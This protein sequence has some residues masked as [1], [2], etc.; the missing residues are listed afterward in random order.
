MKDFFKK[1]V[2][3]IQFLY[4]K[5]SVHLVTMSA[6]GT[7]WLR[8]MI[9]LNLSDRDLQTV[10]VVGVVPH[11]FS[12]NSIPI[13][14]SH[15]NYFPYA[16]KAKTLMLVRDIRDSLV[17]HY[18]T[19]VKNKREDVSFGVFLRDKKISKIYG[20][21]RRVKFLNSWYLNKERCDDFMLVRYEDLKEDTE[22]VMKKVFSFL[23]IDCVD[24]EDT[25]TR[26]SLVEMKKLK[27]PVGK[28][29]KGVVGRYKEYFTKEDEES[30]ANIAKII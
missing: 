11:L 29:K 1:F 4:K 26:S 18:E 23:T 17:S 28:I 19:F 6:S 24:I 22:G 25:I 12:Y 2:S 15:S 21:E 16:R 3:T 14:Q 7:H 27:D 30:F 8:M 20:L 5:E 9:A 13:R 10:D